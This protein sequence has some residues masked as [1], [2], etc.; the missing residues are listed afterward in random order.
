[1]KGNAEHK[2]AGLRTSFQNTAQTL[3]FHF[4]RS[5]LVSSFVWSQNMFAMA[6]NL[7][8]IEYDFWFVTIVFHG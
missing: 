8:K 2:R 4:L 3:M 1:M 6:R 7:I 5:I